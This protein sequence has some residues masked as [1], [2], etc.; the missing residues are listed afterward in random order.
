MTDIIGPGTRV[1]W[2]IPTTNSRRF[3][4]VVKIREDGMYRVRSEGHGILFTVRPALI[5]K[6]EEEP[7]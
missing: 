1:S 4:R 3:G 5:T 7:K 2:P 6:E